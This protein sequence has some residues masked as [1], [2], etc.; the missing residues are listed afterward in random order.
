[1][2]K[3]AYSES[4]IRKIFDTL[5]AHIVI[6]DDQGRIL[7]TNA[8][9]DR[10]SGENRLTG[11]MDFKGMNYLTVCETAT[12]DGAEDAKNVAGGIRDVIENKCREFLYD[13]PCHSPGGKQW[14]YMRAVR[15][16]DSDGVRVIIS[17]EDITELKLAQEALQSHQESLE[18]K[19]QSL[20]EA[21][22]A[23]KVLIR[24]GETDKAEMEQRFL[25]HIKTFV[26]P[27]INKLKAGNLKERDMTLL[28]LLEDQL[29]GVVTPLMQQLSN[30]QVMLT[31][32][33]MQ[34]AALVK[35]GRTS[36]EIADILYISEATVSFHRRN[37]RS[38]LG[39]QNR[40][41]N[42]RSFLLSMS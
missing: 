3:I 27:Y 37:L 31:P 38:K 28:G 16:E 5:S 11:Q 34:V 29:N 15:M 10:F 2:G 14:F 18:E 6:I 35:E 8:A 4:L 41:T 19:N 32:Q 33:E 26:L 36:A 13:Y 23:L 21:N 12:E 20:E 9:W 40:Q 25:T 24:Q 17:H 30:A 7:A 42:L 22:I 1:M 39:L